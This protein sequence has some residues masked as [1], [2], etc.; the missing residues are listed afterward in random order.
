[1]HRIRL[2]ALFQS[3]VQCFPDEAEFVHKN[4]G[5]I[6]AML[7]TDA[8]ISAGIRLGLVL[9]KDPCIEDAALSVIARDPVVPASILENAIAYVTAN[10]EAEYVRVVTIFLYNFLMEDISNNFLWAEVIKLT[11]A[12]VHHRGVD[13]FFRA[14]LQHFVAY[15]WNRKGED[16]PLLKRS[17]LLRLAE[18]CDGKAS[19]PGWTSFVSSVIAPYRSHSQIPR[20]FQIPE[21]HMNPTLIAILSHTRDIKSLWVESFGTRKSKR[22]G[23]RSVGPDRFPMI[24]PPDRRSISLSQPLFPAMHST[25]KK[26]GVA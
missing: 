22:R 19:F 9:P 6:M 25:K 23:T 7:T 24:A 8:E 17:F 12:F 1:M 18:Q 21:K 2:L 4:L 10:F 3:F 11:D 26:C 20:D 15:T 13:G 14:E 5:G 16:C